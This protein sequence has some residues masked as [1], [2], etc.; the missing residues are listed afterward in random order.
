MNLL[1]TDLRSSLRICTLI[2]LALL[3]ACS[4]A[5][6]RIEPDNLVWPLPPNPP[7]IKYIQ[8]IYSEDDIG[9]VYSFKEQLFG[10]EYLDSIVRP[11][12]VSAGRGKIYMTD[13]TMRGIM[14]FDLHARRTS[15]L[16]IERSLEVP[17]SVVADAQGRVFVADPGGGKVSVYD[18][19]GAYR[20]AYLIEG[21][22]P[23]GLAISGSLGRLYVADGAQH[24]VVVLDLDGKQLFAFGGL[25]EEEGKFNLPLALAVGGDGHVYVLDSRNFRVQIFDADGKFLSKFGSVGDQTGMFANPKAIAVDSEGHIYVT[26]AAYNNFQVFDS[27]GHFLIFVGTLGQAPGQFYLPGGIALDENDRIYV[28]D[29]LNR[30]IQVFQYMK[31]Q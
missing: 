1:S 23:L 25:G 30:R 29:Q 18:E 28:A 7:R 27:Q 5:P 4:A 31:D 11:Y 19:H 14:V 15:I 2:V 22:K 20:T 3:S 24:R 26:D 16:G 13:L 6:L 8:S 10:K 9:R 12:G 17:S 21:T